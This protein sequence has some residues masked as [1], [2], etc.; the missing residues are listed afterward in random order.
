MTKYIGA[1]DSGTTSSRFMIF[2]KA[3][4]VVAFDQREHEQ[5]FPQSGWVEHNPLE[6]WQQVQ[7][8]IE[9]TLQK[10]NLTSDSLAAIGITNQRETAIVWNKQTGQPIYN[11]IVWQD[12]RTDEICKTLT[13]AGRADQIYY[14]TGLPIA[15]YFAGPKVRWIL[16][17]VD[18]AQE[19]AEAGELLLGT[20]DTWLIWQLTGGPNGG[21]HITDVT[22][23]S[24]TMLMDLESLTW[25]D[26]LLEI[27]GIP[28]AMLPEIRP[29][30]DPNFYG[31]TVADG[32][33]GGS[34]PI[35]GNLG[36]QQAAT[37]GQTCFSPG[38]AKNTYGTGCF[39]ILNTGTEIIRSQNGLLTTV[40][41]QFGTEPTTYALEGSINMGGA[42]V[43]WLRDS[44]NMIDDAAETETI[45]Q[46]VPDTGGCYL[47]PAFSGLFA[48]YWRSDA[49]GVLVGLTRFINR[50]HIVRAALESICYQTR[51]VLDAMNADSGVPL[52]SLKVDGGA[53]V[54][55]FLMQ[56]QSDILGT[57][58]IRPQVAETTSLGA[59]YAA[60]LAIGY[61]P[62]IQELR[63]NWQVD[64]QW[65]PQIDEQEREIGYAGWKKAVERTFD[66][67]DG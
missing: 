3:G 34:I 13:D 11:A 43:Q 16:D 18:G 35:A 65:Q 24:R 51:E 8:V 63:S 41:Y 6:I 47:V 7:K 39:M 12:L 25:D 32:P 22:N 53:T 44:L 48:P 57:E 55:N 29:S 31:H 28:S 17:N 52:Q 56:L 15:T 62:N 36:D 46:S 27:I 61:W 21:Q 9:T 59:A 64:R 37:V 23:A 54:N 30:S 20:V 40:C 45:A 50:A 26:E 67:V 60:G 49:R 42:T 66:W 14:K 19:A 4:A 33:F 2:D 1:I 38:E 5:I 58:V 10:A